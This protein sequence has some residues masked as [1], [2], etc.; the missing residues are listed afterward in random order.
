MQWVKIG[1]N[2]HIFPVFIKEKSKVGN[3]AVFQVC[4]TDGL[5]GSSGKYVRMLYLSLFG[6]TNSKPGC[7]SK[8]MR[9]LDHT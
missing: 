6:N 5:F 8:N 4:W 2:G 9:H 3:S 7:L 1:P